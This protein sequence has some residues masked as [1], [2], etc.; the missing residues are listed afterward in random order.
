MY[1]VTVLHQDGL[2]VEADVADWADVV[3]RR[4]GGG[5]G[6]E[7]QVGGLGRG[8][9]GQAAHDGPEEKRMG[10]FSC[11]FCVFSRTGRKVLFPLKLFSHGVLYRSITD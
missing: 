1:H 3:H 10:I 6:G 2:C 7:G 9:V 11:G 4:G 8:P 5:G